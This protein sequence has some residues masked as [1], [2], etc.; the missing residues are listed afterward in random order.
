MVTIDDKPLES[1]RAELVSYKV[2]ASDYENGYFLPPASM[3]PVKLKPRIGMKAV[4]LVIDFMGD[5][6]LETMLRISHFTA[7]MQNSPTILLPDGM[8]YECVYEGAT[9]PDEKAPWIWQVK[10]TLSAWRHGCMEKFTLT[11]TDSI[12]VRGTYKTPPVIRISAT[13]NT[14]KVFGITITNIVGEIEIDSINKTITQNGDN[15]FKDTDLVEFPMLDIGYNEIDI[16][17]DAIV[18]VSYYPIYL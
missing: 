9:A 11:H 10:Y 4:L 3:I 17:G 13:S 5:S 2:S 15:K 1:Y 6:E 12:F 8:F 14:V 16:V 18:E 7:M